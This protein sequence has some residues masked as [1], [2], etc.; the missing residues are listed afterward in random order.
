MTTTCS[1]CTKM[2]CLQ[3]AKCKHVSY[4]SLLCQKVH[5][6]E[7]RKQCDLI[8]I[9]NVVKKFDETFMLQKQ[10]SCVY[11]AAWFQYHHPSLRLLSGSLALG[12]GIEEPYYDYGGPCYQTL[13]DFTVH[14]DGEPHLDAHVW[15]EDSKG[16]VYDCVTSSMI[17]VAQLHKKKF[18]FEEPTKIQGKSK[19]LCRELGLHYLEAPPEC[20]LSLLALALKLGVRYLAEFT[21]K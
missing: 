21:K 15:A 19:E 9:Q 6:V 17:F 8:C 3:C 10:D 18:G 7:H 16:H 5:W 2:A 11:F 1:A 4:C 20:N 12:T 13:S 14:Y